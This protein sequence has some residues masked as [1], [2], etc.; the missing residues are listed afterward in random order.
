MVTG[1]LRGRAIAA[2]FL[3]GILGGRALAQTVDIPVPPP[4]SSIDERGVNLTNGGVEISDPQLSIGTSNNGL[5]HTRYWPG[6]N[7]WR[8][9]YMLSIIVNS[10]TQRTVTIGQSSTKFT[11]S[12]GVYVSDKADGATLAQDPSPATT[13]T[14][15]APDGTSIKFSPVAYGPSGVGSASYYGSVNYVGWIITE[16]NG[17]KTTLHH[18]VQSYDRVQ[19]GI[20][21]TFLVVRLQSV[22]T[23]TGFQLKYSYANN[24]L[25]EATV[26]D[27]VRITNVMAINNAVDYCEPQMADSCTGLTQTWPS[28]SYSNATSGANIIE[29][30]TDPVGRV[31][32][33][34]TETPGVGT[35]AKMLGI[36]RPSSPS[37]DNVTYGY[38]AN[39]RV[40]SVAIAGVGTWTYAFTTGTGTLTGTIT[41]PTI[42]ISRV[43]VSNTTYLQPTSVTDE[44]GITSTYTYD[45]NGRLKT[46][47]QPEGN[48]VTYNYDA[49][50]NLTSSVATPKSGSGLSTIT[51]SASYPASCTV[52]ATCNK[53]TT[54]TDAAGKVT[55]YFYNS[56]GTL[57]YVQAPAPSG[58]AARPEVHYSYGNVQAWL[59]NAAGSIVV[60]PDVV[61]VPTG[62]TACITGAWGCA[63]ANQVVTQIGYY[64]GPSATN[65]LVQS[66]TVKSGSGSP[67]STTSYAYDMIGNVTSTTD[68]VSNVTTSA[69]AADR[70]LLYV[71]SPSIDGS[72]TS[73]RREI[74]LHYNGD[75]LVD[76]KSYASVFPNGSGYT[77]NRIEYMGYDGA[78][79]K[80]LDGLTDGTSNFAITQYSYNG[81]GRLDCVAQRMNPATWG[82]LPAACTA[83]TA[84]SYGADRI[85]HYIWEYAGLL[86]RTQSGYGTALQRDDVR[87]IHTLNGQVAT[88]TDAKSNITSYNYDGHDRLIRTC[89]NTALASCSDAAPDIVKLTYD[90]V[91]RLTNRG[92]RGHSLAITIGYGYDDLMRLTTIDY[93]GASIFDSDVTMSY[94][95]LGRMLSANDANTHTSSYGYDALGNVTSQS[96]SIGSRTMLYDAAGRRTRL[97]WN[98]DGRYVTYEYNGASDLTAIKESGTTNLATFAYDDIGRRSTLTRGNGVV[99]TYAYNPL[100]PTSLANDLTGTTYDQTLGF[101]YSPSGQMVTRT[102]SNDAYAWTGAVNVNR[103]YTTNGL[104]QYTASGAI[105]PTYDVKGNLSSAGPESYA[106]STKNELVQ[107]NDTGIQFYHDPLGRMDGVLNIPGGEYGFQ[108]DGAQISTEIGGATPFPILRRY[109]YGPGA[110]E[111][112]VWYEGADFSTKRYLVADERGSIVAVTDTS[113]NPIQINSYDEYGIP[114]GTNLGR[115]QYTGQAWMPELGMY[116]YKARIYSP[117]LGRFLQP[118]PAGYADGP[119]W[120]NYVGSD[121]VN[122]RDPSGL[123]IIA[124]DNGPP[125]DDGCGAVYCDIVVNGNKPGSGTTLNIIK[126]I[127]KIVGGAAKKVCGWL[128][129]CHKKKKPAPAS[130]PGHYYSTQNQI[131]PCAASNA[132]IADVAR[133]FA[134]PGQPNTPIA[135]GQAAIAS[136]PIGS[137]PVRSSYYSYG[138]YNTSVITTLNVTLPG[139]PLYNGSV[140]RDWFRGA[141]GAVWAQTVGRGENSSGFMGGANGLI[142]PP[143]F[144]GLDADAAGY[145]A[146]NVCGAQ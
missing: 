91:G 68:P 127:A 74:L 67:S 70:Q 130:T 108:Y 139:H 14:Y 51:T 98:A 114:A 81:A 29:S 106:F 62:T 97:T 48:Y 16:P 49:R 22:V 110:D 141:D 55:N 77:A 101:A 59:K 8:H 140:S 89:Y 78:G 12:G 96:D 31:E 79:R 131:I 86:D 28:V 2:L 72:P 17:L 50:G 30:V 4:R 75:G 129:L 46:A 26:D 33:Y 42:P 10:A 45:A 124:P 20:T 88:L 117:T 5:T 73:R 66:T 93:P 105:T 111:P 25:T 122:K 56:N 115:F 80:T 118:D 41:T 52:A 145:A 38:D 69:Y 146:E 54:T 121:P 1:Y 109:V 143:I 102:S 82:S 57:D 83:T 23:S 15:T 123:G 44:N 100:G 120:Y 63:A 19:G 3:L 95:N 112:I 103:N 90:S 132:Q 6:N 64:G 137:G 113:G 53:P 133:R 136:T 43:V 58:G 24:T 32:K 144:D 71:M 134:A 35:T 27:W 116:S 7:G 87:Y 60:S 125:Y 85:T 21:F 61:S 65:L 84:G 39:K 104:N 92:L 94:D 138:Q 142:G 99:T 119:N 128:G 11:L 76:S 34:V 135:N 36:R 126:P 40:S 18:K 13:W 47:V 107:R 37:T 9:G